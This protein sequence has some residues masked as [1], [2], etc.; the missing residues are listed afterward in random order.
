[1]DKQLVLRVMNELGAGPQHL[2]ERVQSQPNYELAC[3]ALEELKADAR[4]RYKELAL[5]W[6]PDRNPG[7]P[8]A[9]TLIK[10][11]NRIIADLDKLQ[12]RPPQPRPV[13]RVVHFHRTWP[14]GGSATTTSA[15]GTGTPF[16]GWHPMSNHTANT[17]TYDARQAVFIKFR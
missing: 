8:E 12:L 10:A 7:N 5:K 4:K 11:L 15:A 16:T 13:M 9:E 14:G 1:M 6:H 17:R 3:K 2:Q